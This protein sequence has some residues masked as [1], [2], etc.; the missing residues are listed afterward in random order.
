[1]IDAVTFENSH[2]Y[3]DAIAAQARFRYEQFVAR[4]GWDVPH[5]H[6]HEYD[7]YDNFCATYLLYRDE[8]ARVRGMVRLI[9]TTRRHMLPELWPFLAPPEGLPRGPDIWENTRFAV[10]KGL[11]PRLRREVHGALVLASLEFGL[12]NGITSYLLVSPLWILN[13]SLSAAGL[14]PEI[15]NTT[16]RL[17]PR[18]VGVAKVPVSSATLARCRAQTGISGPVLDQLDRSERLAA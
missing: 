18:P 10:D 11:P 16:D 3:G 17:G 13:G 5:Y 6:G 2:H 7:D 1:M 9:P 15:L 8:T 12:A 14:E 4:D